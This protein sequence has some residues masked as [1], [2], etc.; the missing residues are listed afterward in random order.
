MPGKVKVKILAGR[1]LPV[2]DRGSDTT[3]AF[4]EIKIGTITHK[5]DVCRKSLNPVWNSDWYRFEVDDSDLQ[6]EPLQVR[7]MDYDTYSANDAIGKVYINLS[8]LLHSLTLD[9]PAQTSNTGK[10]SVMSGWIPV[11]DTMNGV[12]GEVHIIVKVDLFTDFN[13]FRQSSCGVRFYHSPIIPHGYSAQV[14]HGFVE[15]LIVN[16]DP[17]YQ[18]IDKIRT[19]RA[20][21][22]ARQIAF[23]K[24]SGQV[25]RKIGLKAIDLGANA[26]VGYSQC[27]DL[28][29][30][31]GVVARGIGTAVT[32][33]KMHENPIHQIVDDPLVEVSELS[34]NDV[35]ISGGTK[36][37]QTSTESVSHRVSQSPAKAATGTA[38]VFL[39]EQNSSSGFY[40][41]SSDSDLSITPR[42]SSLTSNDRCIAV[43]TRVQ[44]TN[45]LIKSLNHDAIDLLEYPFLTITKVP[46][47]FVL[48]IGATV[49]AR[50]VKL[51]A[52]VP[53]PD[54]PET[55]DMWWNE[56]R[57]EIRSHARAIG[58]NMVLG[59]ME[60][61]TISEDVCVL[62]AVGTAAVINVHC[63]L[64]GNTNSINSSKPENS[65]GNKELMTSSLDA[66]HFEKDANFIA[67]LGTSMKCIESFE[68]RKNLE[69]ETS[70]ATSATEFRNLRQPSELMVK[71]SGSIS[72]AQ[73]N[74]ICSICH[75]P[76]KQ[77]S[78]PFRV[79]M[80]KCAICRTGNVPDVLLCTIEIPEGLQVNGRGI[81]I[82]AH[83]CRSKRDLKGES[84]AKEMSDAL[85][86]LEIELHKILINKLKMRGMNAIFG[87]K[88]SVAVGERMMALVA[89]GTAVYLSALP[90]S[91]LPKIL[92]GNSWADSDKL[93]EL[94]TSIHN[95]VE[96]NREFCQLKYPNE[97]TV[98]TR[99]LAQPNDSDDSEEEALDID[100]THDS[101]E[102]CVLELDDLHDLEII[103]LL[104]EPCPPEG[105]DVVNTQTVPGLNDIEVVRNLQMF[106]QVWRAKLPM[107]QS[108]ISF[109]K[110]FQ[111]LLQAIFFKLRAMT[112]CAICDIRFKLDLPEN[113]EIQL[114]VMGMALGL[115]EPSKSN[116]FKKKHGA[117]FNQIKRN[118]DELIF[119]IDDDNVFS[120]NSLTQNSAAVLLSQ[121][122]S[123]ERRR[124]SP[125]RGK[126]G[127][128]R[129]VRHMPLKERYGVDITPLCY[130]PGGK[131][132]K[133]LGNLDF[134]F[135]RECTAV[136]EIGG[137]SGFVH[138]FIAEV[139]AV[140]RAHVTALGG[141]AMVAFYMT[142]LILVDNLHKNQGQCIMSAGGDVVFVSYFKDD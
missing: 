87:I 59:Y 60:S 25:Q 79:N 96:K 76:Y 42:G 73:T 90:P 94:Q 129:L 108:N 61:T 103:S 27:F 84:N 1:N 133:Y 109:S 38:A 66:Q 137:I 102:A 119:S 124:R 136:K 74:N 32:L 18:W 46:P 3:D 89:T 112:P 71:T 75:I 132:E 97:L 113:D 8:P 52:R 106:T 95:T 51:L 130:I 67:D 37:V 77:S 99:S 131:I 2:M 118:D 15:E 120:G 93:N 16:D 122:G 104:M 58:C 69:F 41:R 11:Y 142:E 78:V 134:F 63:G 111:R 14:V 110:H 126:F 86:F 57:M 105:F 127:S 80:M 33:S 65:S 121:T 13:K 20:S 23:I 49:S 50:S 98:N 68:I 139:L 141:N 64:S 6:D 4:V 123:L 34:T 44:P 125:C 140:I 19:P 21:N 9:K 29:G 62:S 82:Q 31:V 17:E 30:D 43:C 12:R 28:E 24:L 114:L 107:N 45:F 101:K 55:R 128:G 83:V 72:A 91:V 85:P 54:D 53:N 135:I 39:K 92:A 35:E 10:G 115:G 138:S 47:G 48:H 56:L 70:F 100:L 5:T 88:T 22:E 26:V 116:A 36:N 7:L 40:R 117:S 81:L